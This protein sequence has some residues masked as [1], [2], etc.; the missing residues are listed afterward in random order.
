MSSSDLADTPNTPQTLHQLA[1]KATVYATLNSGKTPGSSL[2][3]LGN[4]IKTFPYF[5]YWRNVC[6]SANNQ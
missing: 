4:P 6:I 2:A 3:H 5:K 1:I